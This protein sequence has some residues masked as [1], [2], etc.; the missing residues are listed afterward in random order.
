VSRMKKILTHDV[1]L[2]KPVDRVER[3]F[4]KTQNQT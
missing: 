1:R 4:G 3:E 2:R